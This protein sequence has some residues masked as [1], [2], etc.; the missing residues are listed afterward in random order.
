MFPNISSP[1]KPTKQKQDSQIRRKHVVQPYGDSTKDE[2]NK[3]N[4][5]KQHL[6]DMN[7]YS[8]PYGEF[9]YSIKKEFTAIWVP[10]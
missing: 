4:K 10:L 2:N 9:S 5:N 3:A 8:L 6:W 1:K 7:T